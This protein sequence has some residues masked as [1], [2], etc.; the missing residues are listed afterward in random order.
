MTIEKSE[1]Q[2]KKHNCISS[3]VGYLTN[4]IESKDYIIKMFKDEI[5]RK[6]ALIEDLLE[7][8]AYLETRLS[9]I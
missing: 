9:K 8:Q 1:I 2:Q 3:L 5:F 6:N 7:R 4:I